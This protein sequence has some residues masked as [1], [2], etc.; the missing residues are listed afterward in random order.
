MEPNKVSEILKNRREQKKYSLHSVHQ[1]T[2]ISLRYLQAL[3]S[4]EW[5]VFPAE[6][7]LTGFLRKYAAYLGL[8]PELLV[9]QYRQEIGQAQAKQEEQTHQKE[10]LE[11]KK[12]HSLIKTAVFTILIIL[13]VIWRLTVPVKKPQTETPV[14]K[15]QPIQLMNGLAQLPARDPETLTLEVRALDQV[16]VRVIA[17]DQLIFEGLLPAGASRSWQSKN[18]FSVRIGNV[19]AVKVDFNGSPVDIKSGARQSVNDI[20]LDKQFLQTHQS[21]KS[22]EPSPAVSESLSPT[23]SHKKG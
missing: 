9:H 15:P 20:L 6:V 2:K 1:A 23:D 3:E 22:T 13:F 21:L 11:E 17:E 8:D 18:K 7:Y 10:L 14:D 12:N 4:G 19:D 16:W 5:N